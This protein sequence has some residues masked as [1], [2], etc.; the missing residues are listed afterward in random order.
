MEFW[1]LVVSISALVI[2]FVALVSNRQIAKDQQK[3]TR[4]NVERQEVGV[5][6][7]RHDLRDWAS[8]AIE[9]LSEARYGF[10]DVQAASVSNKV[11]PCIPKLSALIDRGRF[12]LPNW[13][14]KKGDQ[15]KP[16][17]FQ[18]YRHR[19][20]GPLMATLNVLNNEVKFEPDLYE[21][22]ED[23][24]SGVIRGLQ[25]DFVSHIQQI[26]DPQH[27]NQKIIELIQTSNEALKGDVGPGANAR[28]R[29]VIV[30][31]IAREEDQSTP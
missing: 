26:P 21:Y 9:V 24:R 12:F 8:D 31:L 23:N 4:E 25:E 17:A 11:P 20:L 6:Q 14:N 19:A 30:R 1:A 27:S 10:E 29:A 22:L 18:G 5:V 16:P 13:G 2:S 15:H 28:L 3:L 7:W